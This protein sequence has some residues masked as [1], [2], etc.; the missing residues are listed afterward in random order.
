ME[1]S[2]CGK[3]LVLASLC[4]N[5]IVYTWSV[6]KAGKRKA[7]EWQH[8]MTLPQYEYPAATISIH[9][10]H[11]NRLVI[12]YT[13]SKLIEYDLKEFSFTYSSFIPQRNYV[14]Q[15]LV[16]EPRL[17]DVYLV[18]T[19]K[20]I[21][22]VT[23]KMGGGGDTKNED[24]SDDE[25]EVNVFGKKAK[26]TN[27]KEAV[28]V[29]QRNYKRRV[30]KEAKHLLYLTWLDEDELVSVELNPVALLEQLPPTLRLKKYGTG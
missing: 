24:E 22:S 11:T 21:T 6:K 8:H 16:F 13:N 15:S 30:I 28:A 25:A 10:Q 12:T 2:S 27:D 7:G 5:V 23:K 26:R 18:Q 4:N 9:P 20:A 3:Y 19:E 29:D 17:N 1:V 14:N